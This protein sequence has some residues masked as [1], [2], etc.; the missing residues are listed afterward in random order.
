MALT[1]DTLALSVRQPWAELIVS[2]RKVMELR[3]WDTDYRGRMWIHAGRYV[4]PEL[5]ELFS[6][7]NAF[8]GGG[9]GVVE[10]VSIE[11]VGPENWES[12]RKYLLDPGPFQPGFF[13]WVLRDP[14]RVTEPI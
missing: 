3:N 5:D 12:W 10:L 8:R 7:H 11:S 6:I 4:D 2:G 13:A 9:V 14:R 1:S